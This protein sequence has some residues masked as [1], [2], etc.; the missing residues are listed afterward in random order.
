M[1]KLEEKLDKLQM[2]HFS[3]DVDYEVWLNV[4]K[5]LHLALKQRDELSN[6][7]SPHSEVEIIHMDTEILKVLEE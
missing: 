2:D 5:A 6:G 1:T 4:I 7:Y 3:G